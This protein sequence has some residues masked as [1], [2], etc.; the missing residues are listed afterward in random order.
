MPLFQSTTLGYVT[1]HRLARHHIDRLGVPSRQYLARLGTLQGRRL[2]QA[3]LASIL[4][5]VTAYHCSTVPAF[6][7][8]ASALSLFASPYLAVLDTPRIVDHH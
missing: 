8:L 6:S 3:L 1:L 7:R 4:C 2:L 5:I